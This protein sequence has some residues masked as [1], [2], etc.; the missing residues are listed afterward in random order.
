[1]FSFSG[2]RIDRHARLRQQNGLCE[3]GEAIW[4]LALKHANTRDKG[5]AKKDVNE[6]H[7]AG[8]NSCIESEAHIAAGVIL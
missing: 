8:N 7:C 1:V 5:S 2:E 3:A 4:P 6:V